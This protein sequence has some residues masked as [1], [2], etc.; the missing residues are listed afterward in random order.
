M[1]KKDKELV[2]TILTKYALELKDKLKRI[3]TI[4]EELASGD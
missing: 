4:L 2:L 1:D 3:E